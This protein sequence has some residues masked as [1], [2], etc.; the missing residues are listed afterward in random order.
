VTASATGLGHA[1][2]GQ[3][4]RSGPSAGREP[5]TTAASTSHRSSRAPRAAGAHH[6]AA[7]VLRAGGAFL[8]GTLLLLALPPYGLWPLAPLGVALLALVARRRTARAGAGLGL[9]AGL[10]YFVPMLRWT[11]PVAGVDAWLML[12]ASQAL[13]WTL[14]GAGLALVTRLRAWPVWA[15]GLWVLSE[16]LRG[17]VPFGGFPWGRLA[18]SQADGPLASWAALGGVPLVTAAVALAGSLIAVAVVHRSSARRA[19]AALAGALAVAAGGAVAPSVL[20]PTRDAG[21][22][23]VAVVQGGVPGRTL[24]T[25]ARERVVLT[26]HVTLT[27]ELARAV[28]AGELRAPDLAVWPENSSDIDPYSVPAARRAIEGAASDLGVPVV[29]GVIERLSTGDR[30]NVSVVVDPETGLGQRYVKRAPVPFAEYMPF[31]P[32]VSQV[33]TRVETLLPTDMVAG[34][35]PGVL[36]VGGVEVGALICFEVVF[37]D[38]VRDVV[39]GG[40]TLIALQTNNATFGE[41]G[42]AEQQVAMARLRAV[43]HGRSVA[44]SS[45]SGVSAVIDP[46]GEVLSA[47][48]TYSRGLLV[49]TVPAREG[50]TP[51]TRL[52]VLPEVSLAAAGLLGLVLAVR[53]RRA[54]RRSCW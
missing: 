15:T 13:Q 10:A 21:P 54:E 3:A 1:P 34:D 46:S 38:L 48:G 22:V 37:D 41:M 28:D 18:M 32:L 11:A 39:E 31:R 19:V 44:V 42:E 36:E 12:A 24:E 40:A 29:A 2:S 49:E 47:T 43:E 20:P 27:G 33:F 25:L 52:G 30:A 4:V 23:T 16:A 5:V 9:L 35:R 7:A 50:L 26:N 51:A 8:S 45:T 53:A 14:V 6:R 17:R